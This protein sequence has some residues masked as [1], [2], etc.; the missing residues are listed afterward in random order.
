M[1]QDNQQFDDR[2]D[3][4]R[5]RPIRPTRRRDRFVMPGWGWPLVGLVCLLAG[6]AL[7]WVLFRSDGSEQA[8]APTTPTI[9]VQVVTATPLPATA[10]PK[11]TATKVPTLAP[12]STATVPAT[13]TPTSSPVPT[14]TPTPE[15]KI[16]VGGKV[17]VGDTGGANLRL[18][19]G[20]GTDYVTFKI[21]NEGVILEVLGG[22][23]KVGDLTW[24]RLQDPVG[25]VGWA[26]E[27][28]LVPVP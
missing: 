8:M 25:V 14:D 5:L 17:K 13:V 23:E 1:T 11:V 20:P 7:G 26:A 10:T 15:V 4:Q 28:W 3:E 9:I 19:S 27:D 16:A 21:V 22:P 6:V 2:M 18:R 24:W 12:Q